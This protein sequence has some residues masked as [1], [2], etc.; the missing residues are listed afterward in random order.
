MNVFCPNC[1]TLYRVDP[2]K[3]PENGVRARCAVCSAVFAVRRDGTA[4][5]TR[6]PAAPAAPGAPAAAA[7]VTTALPEPIQRVDADAE[8]ERVME[9]TPEAGESAPPPMPPAPPAV[10]RPVFPPSPPASLPAAS[11]R[12]G[13]GAAAPPATP[14]RGLSRPATPPAGGS[15]AG[16]AGFPVPPAMRPAA[17]AGARAPAAATAPI[18]SP[19]PPLPA[20]ASPA[21]PPPEAADEAPV[22]PP[23]APASRPINPFLS[24]DPA[25]KARRLARALISDMVVYH[26]AKRQEGLREG[27]L[28]DLFDEEIKKSWEEYS[29]Q[30]GKEV[31]E[32]TSYFKEA[33]N[34]ILA[35]GR[36][37]F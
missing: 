33:L 12:G 28:K 10:E 14:S 20:P 5:T 34:E 16:P 26:P 30:V 21:A 13:P 11:M 8:Q 27:T 15:R 9:P 19:A 6:A 37:I 7:P 29:D 1:N 32:S 36:Q 17:P 4:P 2:G 35:D 24:Q 31:A 3:V 18:A 25:A 22:A 23:P